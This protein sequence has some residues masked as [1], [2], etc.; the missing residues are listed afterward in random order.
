MKD[1]AGV[2]G[3]RYEL[4]RAITSSKMAETK[5]QK[6][7]AHLH[8]IKRQTIKFQISPTK[9]VRGVAGTRS[10][11]RTHTQMEEGHFYSLPPLT[12]GDTKL[13]RGDN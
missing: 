2:A 11:G 8:M 10:D 13:Q 5:N 7:H 1:M 9:D 3:T 4:A 6:P 12:L